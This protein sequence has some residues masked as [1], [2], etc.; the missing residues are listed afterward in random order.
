MVI[1]RSRSNSFESM[2]R[3]TKTS[4]GRNAPLCLSMAST[5]V[6]LPWS[7]CAMIAIFLI[8]CGNGYLSSGPRLGPTLVYPNAKTMAQGS[9]RLCRLLLA[10]PAGLPAAACGYILVFLALQIALELALHP[11]QRVVDRLHMPVQFRRHLLVGLPLQIRG[12]HAALQ[13]AQV[14]ADALPHRLGGFLVDDELLRVGHLDANDHVEQRPV[15]VFVVDR[16][17]ERDV[18]VERDVL[19]TGGGL[20]GGDDLPGDAEFRERAERR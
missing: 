17:V 16:L 14:L 8:A 15:G 4:L 2:T 13:V 9:H 1:P 11:L 12:E 3:S 19:L 5:R 18:G 20:D 6:V 10:P 7:T